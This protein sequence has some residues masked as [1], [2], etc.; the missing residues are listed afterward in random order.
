MVACRGK[1]V[2]VLNGF[3]APFDIIN[4]S[5]TKKNHH[6]SRN[7]L[8]VPDKFYFSYLSPDTGPSTAVMF[9]RS[10]ERVAATG[11][12][13]VCSLDLAHETTSNHQT[14]P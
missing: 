12:K 8:L 14:T 1:R 9:E 4:K 13:S 11:W 2:D 3:E 7:D 5:G 10:G 6:V